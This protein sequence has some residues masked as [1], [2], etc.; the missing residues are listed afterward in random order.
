MTNLS[1]RGLEHRAKLLEDR[2]REIRDMRNPFEKAAAAALVFEDLAA[3][4]RDLA[5]QVDALTPYLDETGG[6]A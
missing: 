2:A 1:K 6:A 5:Q 4:M 3:F